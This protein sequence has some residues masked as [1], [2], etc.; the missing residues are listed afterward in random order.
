[1]EE[2]NGGST[3]YLQGKPKLNLGPS[4]ISAALLILFFSLYRTE[5]KERE[6]ENGK[7]QKEKR[8]KGRVTKEVSRG[9]ILSE[10]AF[11]PVLFSKNS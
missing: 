8:V 1:M 7:S 4:N 10:I 5:N 6:R 2:D 3:H 9:G 11:T